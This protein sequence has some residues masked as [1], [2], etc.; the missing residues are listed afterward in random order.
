MIHAFRVDR[1]GQHRG[2]PEITSAL[3]LFALLRRFTLAVASTAELSAE[4][5]GV[6]ETDQSPDDTAELSD[7]GYMEALEAER[8]MFPFLPF[9][10]KA[11]AFQPAQPASTYAEFKHELINEIARCLNIPYNVAACNSS[12]Y[13]YASGRLDHQVYFKSIHVDQTYWARACLDRLLGRWLWE[14]MLTEPDLIGLLPIAGPRRVA[15]P[16]VWFWDGTE[17]V[18]PVKEEK[19][20]EMRLSTKSS[21]MAREWAAQGLDWETDGVEQIAREVARCH[22]LGIRHPSEAAAAG[23]ASSDEDIEQ[24]AEAVAELLVGAGR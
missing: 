1:P 6:I 5:A 9:G 11:H 21:T 16:H 7:E 13:N 4:H 14:M 18:D 3:P 22:E 2:V 10:W 15:M 19:A 17:H 23:G 24:I 12:A 8:G 20:R